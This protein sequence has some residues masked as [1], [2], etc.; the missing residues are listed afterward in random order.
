MNRKFLTLDFG[1]KSPKQRGSEAFASGLMRAEICDREFFLLVNSNARTPGYTMK[2]LGEH[3]T[4]ACREWIKGWDESQKEANRTSRDTLF[5]GSDAHLLNDA[6]DAFESPN[7]G[8][9]L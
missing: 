2:Q 4:L 1:A 7:R 5:D 8:V 6:G 9:G 3:R